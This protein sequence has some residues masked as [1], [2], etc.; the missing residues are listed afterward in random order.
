MKSEVTL[1]NARVSH[2]HETHQDMHIYIYKIKSVA[3]KVT[4]IEE[5]ETYCHTTKWMTHDKLKL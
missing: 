3:R 5:T 4:R 2:L 1:S